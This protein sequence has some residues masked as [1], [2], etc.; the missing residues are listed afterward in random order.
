MRRAERLFQIIQILRRSSRPVTAAMLAA[1]LE[2]SARS[3]Y[4]DIAHLMGQRVPIEGTAGFGYLLDRTFDMPPLMLT[5][6]E[7]E[8]A[9]LGAEW[10]AARGDPA[11]A[12]A[13]R[14]LMAKIGA[15]LPAH[16]RP[17]MLDPAAGPLPPLRLE[18]DRI[19][20]AQTRL[21]IR[22]GRK[23]QIRY[24][25]QHGQESERVIWPVLI[26]YAEAVRLL[27]GWCEWRQAF[28]SFRSDRV[29]AAVFLAETYGKRPAVLRAEWQRHLAARRAATPV[30]S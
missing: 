14:D 15:V 7:L 18:P 13:A 28:R 27:V 22:Q 11:L 1:E 25:D 8:A 30:K 26:G 4:R 21:W 24:Q 6:D 3:V 19:D 12:A 5:P 17:V 9:A 29:L 23:I 16:L 10:V 2:V 20:I